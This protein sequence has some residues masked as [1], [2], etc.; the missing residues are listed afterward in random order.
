MFACVCPC[1]KCWVSTGITRMQIL[2]KWITK[3]SRFF[4]DDYTSVTHITTIFL[5]LQLFGHWV[6]AWTNT[7]SNGAAEL[8]AAD[9]IHCS[10]QTTL[11]L[12]LPTSLLQMTMK[13]A[14]QCHPTYLPALLRLEDG[15]IK[16][17][18][19]SNEL[20]IRALIQVQI[21]PLLQNTWLTPSV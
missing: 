5:L 2:P 6:T 3:Y 13:L 12:M 19:E 20:I 10:T 21:N 11:Q 17:R 9:I 1:H 8:V 15:L 7:I 16:L 18:S 14:R 4:S